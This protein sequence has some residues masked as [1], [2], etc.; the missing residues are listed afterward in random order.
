MQHITMIDRQQETSWFPKIGVYDF[1]HWYPKSIVKKWLKKSIERFLMKQKIE[2]N[3]NIRT[4]KN[5]RIDEDNILTQL[6]IS[7]DVL[8]KAHMQARHILIGRDR[9]YELIGELGS[10]LTVTGNYQDRME[11]FGMKLTFVPWMEGV[12]I[13]PKDFK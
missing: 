12:L 3:D 6:K 1:N 2:Y 7:S 11:V 13:L 9:Y 8:Y 5:V 4:Y 10:M